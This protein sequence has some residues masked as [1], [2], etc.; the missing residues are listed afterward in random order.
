MMAA[1]RPTKISFPKM[2]EEGVR[3]LIAPQ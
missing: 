3:G 1:A 2:R